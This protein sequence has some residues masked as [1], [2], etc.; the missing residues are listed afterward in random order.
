MPAKVLVIGAS[1]G[2]GLAAVKTCL[3]EGYQVRAFARTASQIM[4]E[5]QALETFAGD[6]LDT[7]DIERAL[8]DIDVA[9]MPM[10]IP[11][12]RM[13]PDAA[14]ECTKIIDPEVVYLYHFDQDWARRVVRPDYPRSILPSGLSIEETL[15]LFEEHMSGSGIEVRRGDF[16]PPLPN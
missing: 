9:F 15:A 4:I 1:R 11:V 6:A 13:N 5:D 10:N 16:Y 14:A 2:I 3:A 12:G 8:Q 7:H